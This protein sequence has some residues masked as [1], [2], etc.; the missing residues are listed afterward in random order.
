MV[1]YSEL[2]GGTN[3]RKECCPD[4]HRYKRR[5]YA[6]LLPYYPVYQLQDEQAKKLLSKS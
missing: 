4:I 5:F 3:R 1:N 6:R 2:V